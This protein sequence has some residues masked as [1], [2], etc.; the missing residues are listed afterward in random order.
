MNTDY[1]RSAAKLRSA[2]A[3]LLVASAAPAWCLDFEYS[4]YRPDSLNAITEQWDA[5]TR[6]YSPGYSIKTPPERV[7]TTVIAE[8]PPFPCDTSTLELIFRTLRMSSVLQQVPVN[9]CIRVTDPTSRKTVKAYMQDV[10]VPAFSSETGTGRRVD[11]YVLFVAY[12]VTSD[13]A[14]NE[15]VFLVNEFNVP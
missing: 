12:A 2:M 5:I 4:A 10:L 3:F 8:G 6:S 7:K 11:L 14:K 15:P 1:W 9:H 13:R